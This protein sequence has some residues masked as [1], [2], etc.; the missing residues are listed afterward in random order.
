[1]CWDEVPKDRGWDGVLRDGVAAAQGRG[2]P[3]IGWDVTSYHQG[4][5]TV[6]GSG[7]PEGVVG[8]S[9]EMQ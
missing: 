4:G 2:G 1:M 3:P 9:G 8:P 6:A 7:C 5:T